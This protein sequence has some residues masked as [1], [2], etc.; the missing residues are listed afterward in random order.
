MMDEILRED[1]EADALE[2]IAEGDEGCLE[3]R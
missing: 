3:N 1:I 2:G